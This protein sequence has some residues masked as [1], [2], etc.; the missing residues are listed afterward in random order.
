MSND[1]TG[2]SISMFMVF[3]TFGIKVMN[4]I[5][6]IYVPGASIVDVLDDGSSLSYILSLIIFDMDFSLATLVL[7]TF[8]IL[9]LQIPF[10]VALFLYGAF[11]TVAFLALLPVPALFTAPL[12]MGALLAAYTAIAQV[13]SRQTFQGS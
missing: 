5:L 12:A 2:Y 9:V 4:Y 11:T 6:P 3:I 13:T 8:S 10:I 1:M 7:F